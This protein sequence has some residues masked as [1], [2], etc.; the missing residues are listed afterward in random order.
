[1]KDE[2][3]SNVNTSFLNK[4]K[5]NLKKCKSFSFSVSFIKKAGLV[6]LEREIEEALSKDK[7]FNNVVV[8]FN[9]SKLSYESDETFT[10]KELNNLVKKQEPE[11]Y[12]TE[13][14]EVTTS[15]YSPL[16]LIIGLVIGLIAYFIKMPVIIKYILY[17]IAYGL[18][19]YKTTINAVK[20]L[21]KSKTINE[22][23]LITI[24]CLGALAIGEVLEGMMVV[25]LYT[26]GKIL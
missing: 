14:E 18:L 11:A 19:L 5:S 6:L 25:A 16:T 21:I 3:L 7:R 22:N 23:F 2:F 24:S 15:E 13:S 1:M 9:T 20:L 12:L 26:I 4:I 8:N 10:L 17:F